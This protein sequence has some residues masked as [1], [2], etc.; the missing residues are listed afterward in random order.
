MDKQS[1]IETLEKHGMRTTRPR[2]A[3]AQLLFFDGENKHVSAEWVAEK[4][5]EAEESISL[6]SVYNTLNS[7]V[8]VGLLRQIQLGGSH[9]VFDTNTGAHHHFLDVNTGKL[10]D[11]PMDSVALS[12]MPDVPEG[13]ELD[14]WELVIRVK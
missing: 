8:E 6:A 2:L 10:T 3:V 1:L 9:I 11:I 5:S 14:G 4:L 13:R 12:Q 7:F